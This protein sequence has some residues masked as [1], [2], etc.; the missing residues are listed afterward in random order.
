MQPKK[1]IPLQLH[2]ADSADT[3]QDRPVQLPSDQVFAPRAPERWTYGVR[4]LLHLSA[5]S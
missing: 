1:D 4:V 5:A 2:G 3:K